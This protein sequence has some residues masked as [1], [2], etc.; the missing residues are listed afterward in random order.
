V[1]IVA[2]PQLSLLAFRLRTPGLSPADE[3]ARN[4]RWM[5]LV[6]QKQR[7]LLT[8]TTTQGRFLVR[9]CILSFRTHRDRIDMAIE[10][11]RTSREEL[12]E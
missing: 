1:E 4:R 10:D 7:V 9:M 5:S 8:G 2:E 11:L 12:N 6:N 3:D